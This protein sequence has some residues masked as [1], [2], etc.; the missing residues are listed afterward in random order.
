MNEPKIKLQFNENLEE[1]PCAFCGGRCT[2]DGLDFMVEGTRALVCGGCVKEKDPDLFEIH[3]GAHRWTKT[4]NKEAYQEGHRD[5]IQDGKAEAGRLIF[6][7]IREPLEARLLRLL[8]TELN[9]KS[10]GVFP[11]DDIPF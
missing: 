9:V 10:S 3:E 5:G 4:K 6:E 11:E 8:E 2:P 1:G 7:A